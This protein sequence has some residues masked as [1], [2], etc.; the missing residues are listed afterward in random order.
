MTSLG[1]STK[2]QRRKELKP[3]LLKLFQKIKGEGR[4]PKSFYETTTITL[5]SKPH[6]HTT[7]KE[8]YRPISFINIDVKILNKISANQIQQHIKRIIHHD[9]L[10]LIPGSQGW[11]NICKSIKVITISTKEDKKLMLNRC[12]KFSIHL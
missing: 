8:K 3:A 4:L 11:F 10:A 5:I 2:Q 9:Q 1:I 6:K 7:K 12:K